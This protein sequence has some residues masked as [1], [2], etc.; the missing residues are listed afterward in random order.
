[1][2]TFHGYL[3][4][5]GPAGIRNVVLVISGDL[6]CNPWSKEIA[7]PFEN[8]WALLHKHGVGNYAPDRKLFKRLISGI[9]VHPNVAGFVFVSSGNEDHTPDEILTEA[10]KAGKSYSVV[11]AKQIKG[12]AELIRKGKQYA[13]RLVKEASQTVRVA[14]GIDRLRIGLN[15]AGTDTVS[16]ETVHVV[17]GKAADLITVQGGTVVVSE[18]PDLIGLGDDLFDRCERKSDRVKLMTFLKNH[19]KRLSATGEKIDDIEMVAFNV[20]GGLETLRQ[21]AYVSIK[22]AGTGAIRE[23]VEY[24][25]IPSKTGLVFMDGAAM[26]DFVLTG[27]MGAGI[28]IMINTCGAGEGN[29]MPFT[30]GADT[31]SPILPVLKMTGSTEH[32][33]Q[34]INRIDFN[35]ATLLTGRE[36]K[37]NAAIRLLRMIIAKASGKT[38][39]TEIGQ[40]FLLNIPVQ[41]PQA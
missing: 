12:G 9:T 41:Y 38:T 5:K 4:K 22:K 13:G 8:C 37:E 36:D 16:A 17:C 18:T 30:V 35:A 32:F 39:R 14:V 21:K 20:D 7:A 25:Q 3:R 34:K 26:T 23:V 24:G 2:N 31:P 6:C 29:K 28:H 40:D 10:E 1:M 27:Y 19:E 33:R 11:S 15:C